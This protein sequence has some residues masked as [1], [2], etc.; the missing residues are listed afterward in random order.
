MW[1]WAWAEVGILGGCGKLVFGALFHVGAGLPT[2]LGPPQGIGI[3]PCGRLF[4]FWGLDRFS[5]NKMASGKKENFGNLFG[6]P[7]TGFGTPIK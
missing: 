2:Y 4:F 7:H 6:R 3:P 1:L 5:K